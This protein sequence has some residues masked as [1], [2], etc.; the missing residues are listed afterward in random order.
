MLFR[1]IVLQGITATIIALSG[2]YEQILNYVV[3]VDFIWFGLTGATLFVFRRRMGEV[4]RRTPGHPYTTFF[5]VACCWAVVAATIFKYPANSAVG[6]AIL[7]TGVPV[8]FF[9]RYHA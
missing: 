6:L 5:F 1:S 9:W 8:Y 7:A 2:R 4:A 3:S